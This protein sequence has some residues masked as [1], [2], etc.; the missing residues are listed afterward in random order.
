MA[1]EDKSKPCLCG[2]LAYFS[3]YCAAYI[4][5]CGNHI[6]MCRCFCGWA[7]SGGDGRRELIEEGET[8]EAEDY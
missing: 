1:L 5:E 2:S 3:R 6:G 7:A 4:C 8:I